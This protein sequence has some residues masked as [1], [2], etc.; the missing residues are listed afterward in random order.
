MKRL[1]LAG[2]GQ[3]HVL[4]LREI[5]RRRMIDV[6]IV[7]LAPSNQLRYSGMLPGWIAGHYQLEE[8]TIDVVPLAQAAGARLVTGHVQKLDLASKVAFT[9]RGEAFD[10]DVLSIATGAAIDVDAITGAREHAL[11][12]RPYEGFI[13]GWQHIV[14]RAEIARGTFRL[15]VIGGGAAGAETALAAAYR[16]RTMQ[17][18]VHVQLLTGGVPILP[19]HGHRAR[20]LMSTALMNNGV[21]MLDTIAL[22]VESGTVITEGEHTIATDAALIATGASPA[23]WLRATGLALD[24]FG[25]VAVN[26]RLQSISH[27]FVFAAGDAA[28]LIETPRPKSGVYA[29]RAAPPLGNNLIAALT[30]RPL[31]VFKPQRRALYLLTTGPKHAI[32]SWGPWAFAGRWVWHWKN[33]IDRDYIAKFRRPNPDP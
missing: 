18:P 16:V 6:E 2:G 10:F 28:T 31:S 9:D 17:L 27:S 32:A 12:L 33:R 25:F 11:A 23:A 24:E 3:A 7:V 5:A 4:V 21:Q 8:L 13:V 29:V 30:A 22:R 1:L 26:S 19:G 20:S 15:T 14:R